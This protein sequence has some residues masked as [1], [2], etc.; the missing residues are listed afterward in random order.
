MKENNKRNFVTYIQEQKGTVFIV[1]FALIGVMLLIL[2]TIS[3]SDG[4][5]VSGDRLAQYERRMEEKIAELCSEVKGVKNVKVSI[6][7]NSGF[8]S[9][10]AFDEENR[11]SS[12]GINSEKKYVT[13]GSGNDE[14]LVCL[15][16]RM[17][18]I[19]G[20]AIVCM[21]GS[22]PIISSELINLISSAFEVPKNKIYVTEGK[23]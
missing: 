5:N 4:S 3:F 11:S 6:Y 17:P 7:F 23:K 12:G 13:L 8:E 22:D 14:S 2:P 21:G 16:E 1:A 18:Q 10:Y 20:I 19:S 15:Y 9:V